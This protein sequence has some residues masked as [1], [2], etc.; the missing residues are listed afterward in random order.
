VSVS[1]SE[2]VP[3]VYWCAC[4]GYCVLVNWCVCVLVNWRA[5]V[6]VGWCAGELLCLCGEQVL[7][8]SFSKT[9]RTNVCLLSCVGLLHV[10]SIDSFYF[11][12]VL[13]GDYLTHCKPDDIVST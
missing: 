8:V 12:L 10:I 5:C 3:W 13:C 2:T 11:K 1:V 6:L 4:V 9:N 7:L